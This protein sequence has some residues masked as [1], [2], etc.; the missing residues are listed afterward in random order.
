MLETLGGSATHS[1]GMPWLQLQF[2]VQE[3]FF[4]K[5]EKITNCA[6]SL[7]RVVTKT[8][9][10]THISPVRKKLHWLPFEYRFVLRRCYLCTN[11]FSGFPDYFTPYIKPKKFT[12][13]TRS[14]QSDGIILD[15]PPCTSHKSPKQFGNSFS[16]DAP[17]IWKI[18]LMMFVLPPHSHLSDAG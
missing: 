10:Y 3:P 5:H 16:F 12:Y 4:T 6:N 2:F 18:F 8:T 14:S 15:V 9:R 7:A 1:H 11:S 17:S 13:M